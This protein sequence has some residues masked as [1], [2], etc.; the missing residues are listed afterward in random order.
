MNNKELVEKARE[1]LHFRQLS[2]ECSVGEVSAA[3]L[4]DKGNIY[5]GISISAAFG[6]LRAEWPGDE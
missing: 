4:T 5:L 2:E 6:T 1:V 3:L